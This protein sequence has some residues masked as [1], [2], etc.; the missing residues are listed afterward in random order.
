MLMTRK[1]SIGSAL[2]VATHLSWSEELKV[3][4]HLDH[5]SGRV[6]SGLGSDAFTSCA[7][8]L[9]MR[10]ETGACEPPKMLA[11]ARGSWKL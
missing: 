1:Q 2:A 10:W 6:A 11:M 4:A 9:K 5:L 8:C 7:N 3:L